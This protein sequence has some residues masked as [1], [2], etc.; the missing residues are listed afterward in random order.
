[1]VTSYTQL[2]NL[3][4]L[5]TSYTQLQNLPTIP[6]AQVQADW[7]ETVTTE[8]DFIKNKQAAFNN[9]GN[10]HGT[11]TDFN[12]VP[13]FGFW[14]IQ[15]TGNSPGTNS[16]TQYYC[17]TQGLGNEYPW[18]G[19]NS[20]G[21]QW[22][23]PR[24]VDLPYIS[25]RYKENNSFGTWRKI[26]AGQA[27]KLTTAR[28]IAGTSF[29]GTADISISYNNL[30]NKL[31]AGT[32]ILIDGSNVISATG[33][34]G[35]WDEGT[36]G[37]I[38]FKPGVVGFNDT[39]YVGIGTTNPQYKLHV[40]DGSVFIGDVSYDSNGLGT[41]NGHRLF[42]DNTFN[43]TEGSGTRANKIILHDNGTWI[44][45]FGL[46]SG[47][48]TYHSGDYHRF[49]CGT[50][51]YGTCRFKFNEGKTYN[52]GN[53]VAI[54]NTGSYAVD[55]NYMAAGSLTIG[56]VNTNFGGGWNWSSNT[57]GLMMECADN[58][59]IVV[60]DSGS[61]LASLL[62]YAGG[63]NNYLQIGRDIGWGKYSRIYL[64][65]PIQCVGDNAQ[66]NPGGT[67][68]WFNANGFTSTGYSNVTF[69]NICAHF[70]SSVICYGDYIANSD[71]RIKKNI[72]DISDNT[73]LQQILS[74]EP[75]TYNY[76]DEVNKGSNKVYGFIAQQIREVI[77]EAVSLD[78]QI[79][80]N[81][82]KVCDCSLNKIYVDISNVAVNT[83]ID[84]I[85]L[86]E[87]RQTYT[88]TDISEG[89]ITID[90]DLQGDKCFVYGTQI[91]DFHALNKNYIFTLNVC[92]TQLLSQ[93]ID[94][95]QARLTQLENIINNLNG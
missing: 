60:H 31:T 39:N 25:I 91:D 77:P 62:Y 6:A 51:G 66:L 5:V 44:A 88:I 50:S 20:Y 48:V 58:T 72:E 13:N 56:S 73:A 35:L 67:S 21:M 38:Y 55:N 69:S 40:E 18:T 92:A 43:G 24:N 7:N 85:D 52:Y 41:A 2:T 75:K 49:Y 54:C 95:L 82:Y 16:G 93:K 46:E 74:I 94:D 64:N 76:I 15:G 12:N 14:F 83:K 4:N 86:S 1:M 78:K 9:Q 42:F 79:I 32:G 61:R 70:S 22:G 33:G 45:G 90:K 68:R 36:N 87:N 47:G 3:P 10:N 19:A 84:I 53:A 89:F 65:A 8:V 71:S 63:S 29:N 80:P 26:S 57:A 17:L 30:T 81:I 59:E 27:D 23:I 28:N 37:N 11:Y 34:G